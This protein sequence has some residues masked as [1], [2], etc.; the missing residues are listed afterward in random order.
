MITT[1]TGRVI[2]P[3]IQK[4]TKTNRGVCKNVL[5]VDTW[6]VD[7]GRQE[8][9]SRGDSFNGDQF[10]R[11]DPKKITR[12]EKDALNWYL[13]GKDEILLDS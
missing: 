11:I 5:I 6:L 3:P 10:D 4:S 13:F 8:A 2:N 7:Q 12:A 9:R 1:L